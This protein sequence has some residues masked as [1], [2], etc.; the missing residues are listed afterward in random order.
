MQF[1]FQLGYNLS[2]NAANGPATVQKKIRDRFGPV[3]DRPGPEPGTG[4]V[5]TLDI[6]DVK[7]WYLVTV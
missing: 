7:M 1:L 6:S 5:R 4:P 3:L 2:K